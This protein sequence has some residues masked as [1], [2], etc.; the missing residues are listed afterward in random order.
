MG[1][2]S[3]QGHSVCGLLGVAECW[4]CLRSQRSSGWLGRETPEDALTSFPEVP[5]VCQA[6]RRA[7]LRNGTDRLVASAD[8]W[9]AVEHIHC[10]RMVP[11]GRLLTLYSHLASRIPA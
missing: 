4:L 7:P 3:R 5:A 9:R 2:S 1:R 6:G 11:P 8:G 10:L